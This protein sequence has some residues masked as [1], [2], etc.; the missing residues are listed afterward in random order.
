MYIHITAGSEKENGSLT[1]I[2]QASTSLLPP[3][4]IRILDIFDI[5]LHSQ[6]IND[7]DRAEIG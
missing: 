3:A 4:V 5:S 1:P 2:F 6:F 7:I